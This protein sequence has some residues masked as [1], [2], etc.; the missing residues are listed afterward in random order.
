[1]HDIAFT[2]MHGSGNHFVL[3]DNRSLRAP[4]ADMA[5]WARRICAPGF[6]VGAD[7]LIFLDLAP[8]GSGADT[9][10]HFYNADGSR[11]EMCGNGSRCAARLAME[12]GMAGPRH[13]LLTDAGPIHAAVDPDSDQVK[14]QLT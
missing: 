8:A 1:M 5:E 9:M 6:G 7:G 4:R 10:W 13:V 12:L 3:L 2:K 14:V 11:A